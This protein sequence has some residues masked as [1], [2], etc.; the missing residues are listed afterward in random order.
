[1]KLYLPSPNAPSWRGARL[2]NHRDSFTLL[3][4]CLW[5][6]FNWF[7]G[8][9]AGFCEHDDV[10]SG[11][12]KSLRICCRTCSEYYSGA[13]PHSYHVNFFS[14]QEIYINMDAFLELLIQ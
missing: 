2:N 9:L 10:L 13:Y 14:R 1:V 3:Y 8:P 7:R 4:F 12:I 11:F 6:I 5:S